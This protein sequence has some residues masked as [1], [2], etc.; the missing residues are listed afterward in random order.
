VIPLDDDDFEY[1]LQAESRQPMMAQPQFAAVQQPA[2]SAAADYLA[3]AR[4]ELG[5]RRAGD[6]LPG[7]VK[8][9]CNGLGGAGALSCVLA[10]VCV[11]MLLSSDTDSFG[12]GLVLL[13]A[14]AH[15]LIGIGAITVAVMLQKRVAAALPFGFVIAVLLLCGSPVHLICGIIALVGLS[16]GEMSAYLAGRR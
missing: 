16:S 12:K 6:N 14:P 7:P 5:S 4:S 15:L 8:M 2:Q 10:I 11:L 3:K 13:I 9:A 1:A